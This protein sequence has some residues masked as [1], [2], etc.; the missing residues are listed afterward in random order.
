MRTMRPSISPA[1]NP[2]EMYPAL[3]VPP[4]LSCTNVTLQPVRRAGRD[5]IDAFLG[6]RG[7]GERALGRD[8]LPMVTSTPT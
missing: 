8:V 5:Q 1:K 7:R 2:D 3:E 6:G 4:R